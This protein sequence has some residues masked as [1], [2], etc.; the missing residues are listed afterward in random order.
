MKVLYIIH[1]C[2]MGGATISFFNM[3]K[4]LKKTG[5]NVSVVYPLEKD[6]SIINELKEL[7]CK[8]IG[9]HKVPCSWVTFSGIKG[10]IIFPLTLSYLLLSKIRFYFQ[11]KKIIRSELPDIIHTNTGVVHE[12]A[13]L[14]NKL[15]IPH[16][17]HL[18]EYQLKDFKGHPLPTMNNFKKKLRNSY[19]VC[20][21]KDIQK[22]F[23]LEKSEKSSVIYNP[24][25]SE[26]FALNNRGEVLTN[27]YFLVANR[28]SKEKGIEDTI[29]AFSEF[30]KY[31]SDYK[32]KICG[33]GEKSYIHYL[34]NLCKNKKIENSVE[35]L[36]YADTTE[37]YNMMTNS[38]S[39]IVSS[40]NEG[41]G[42]MTAEANMLGV[43]VIGRSSGGTKEILE[44]TNGGFLFNDFAQLVSSMKKV[45]IMS[46]LEIKK[47]ME[48]AQKKAI[49]L[50]SEEQ[51][52]TKI[53]NLYKEI[54]FCQ[55][56]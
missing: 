7:K 33:F 44:Q 28:I 50:F 43:P 49:S 35:F 13:L 30:L 4:G 41:F 54:K 24:A 21:T 15:H 11:L 46:E 27:P 51:H 26:N 5:I 53:L 22:Y 18:R 25:M 19:T 45:S 8:C 40:Y 23:E 20:I 47:K 48:P 29:C 32:L 56:N 14:A 55:T 16:V 2:T 37:I 1:S 10:K 12:G 9:V 31:S 34:M 3:I 6:I 39:L 38:K 52:C 17:W 42:R 36:G